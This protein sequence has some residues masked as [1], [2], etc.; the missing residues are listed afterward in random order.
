MKFTDQVNRFRARMDAAGT[1]LVLTTD[2][3]LPQTSTAL[4]K[5]AIA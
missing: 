3:S 1:N 4:K 2:H 5:P